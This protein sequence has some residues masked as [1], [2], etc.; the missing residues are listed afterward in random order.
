[1]SHQTNRRKF[2][3]SSALIGAGL[4]ASEGL[5]DAKEPKSPIEKLNVAFVGVG[6]MGGGNLNAIAG[7]GE[8][9]V[10]LCDIDEKRLGSAGGKHTKAQKFVD[11]RKM[12]DKIGKTVDAVVVSTPDNTHAVAGI[13][14]MKMGKHLYCEKP[15]THDVYEARLM[16][17]V[18]K[19]KKVAT[20]MGNRGTAEEG[21]RRGV[22]LIQSGFLGTVKEAYV[23]TNRPGRWWKQGMG[24]PKNNPPIPKHV[25]WDLW[26][27]PA[28]ERPYN[29]IYHPFSWRGWVD[30]GT[31]A[32][33]DMACHTMNL[34]FMGLYLS[35]PTSVKSVSSGIVDGE[36][37]PIWSTI[38]YQFPKRRQYAPVTLTWYDGMKSPGKQNLPPESVRKGFKIGSSGSIIVG[39]KA[40]LFSPND[41]GSQIRV[42]T[43]DGEELKYEY[44]ERRLSR[45]PGG[46]QYRDWIRACKGGVP[47]LANFDYSALLTES[48]LLGNAALRAESPIEYDAAKMEITN[49]KSGTE[50]LKREYRKGWTL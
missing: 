30:F 14:A 23:W 2:L 1:M 7:A 29:P 45:A 32:L 50:L 6:G 18:A 13:M 11:F 10:G 46:S 37:Y 49:L 31:G 33:G 28:K 27:G 19:E 41:Y 39:D 48:V 17:E 36:T 24:R 38:T 44:P 43:P 12:L 3:Q 16:Q 34:P 40:T 5:L 47:A 22:E 26:L 4:W 25:N 20:C 15:L 35:Y 9:V 8:N 42:F 21:F